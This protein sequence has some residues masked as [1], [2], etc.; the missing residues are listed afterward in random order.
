[1]TL[2]STNS[3]FQPNQKYLKFYNSDVQCISGANA[4]STLPLCDIKVSYENYLRTQIQ[5][6]KGQL[7]YVLSFPMIGIKS[8]FILIKINY[9]GTEHH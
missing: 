7:D 8:T 3:I 6:P 5:I 9:Q 2:I 1:M 4:I